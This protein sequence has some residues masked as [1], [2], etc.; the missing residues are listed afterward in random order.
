MKP[1]YNI[2]VFELAVQVL[3]HGLE[4]FLAILLLA[5]LGI[6]VD[7]EDLQSAIQVRQANISHFVKWGTNS[8]SSATCHITIGA[9][10]QRLKSSS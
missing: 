6:T 4:P 3:E 7:N 5:V 8:A 10:P 1:D 2:S 9:D